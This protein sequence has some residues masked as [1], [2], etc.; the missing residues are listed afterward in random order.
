MEGW[1][2]SRSLARL[3]TER[4][5]GAAEANATPLGLTR[6]NSSGR[7]MIAAMKRQSSLSFIPTVVEEGDG[8]DVSDSDG[9]VMSKAASKAKR[10]SRAS[11]WTKGR[12]S[13]VSN[14]HGGDDVKS[15]TTSRATSRA[16]RRTMSGAARTTRTSR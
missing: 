5:E 7:D 8:D 6:H 15:R 11:I 12:Q 16:T 10:A 13:T 14:S 2:I 1:C 9:D 4:D 3:A